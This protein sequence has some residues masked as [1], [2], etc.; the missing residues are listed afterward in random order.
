MPY[1]EPEIIGKVEDICGVLKSRGNSKPLIVTDKTVYSLG[2][3]AKLE[4]SLKAAGYGYCV[5]SDVV[6]NLTTENVD[7]AVKEYKWG[8]A[9]AL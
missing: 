3:C 4:E 8:N 7:G 2:L 5:Y 9:P 1:R 6:A